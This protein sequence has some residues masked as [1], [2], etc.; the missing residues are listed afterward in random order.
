MS[1]ISSLYLGAVSPLSGSGSSALHLP[2]HHLTTHGVV[3]GMT[4]SGKSGLVTVLVEEALR[5]A[6]PVLV[7]E[8][9]ELTGSPGAPSARDLDNAVS[10]LAP[11]WFLMRDAHSHEGLA[12]LQPRWAMSYLRGPMTRSEIQRALATQPVGQGAE[13]RVLGRWAAS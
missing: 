7:I 12:L 13:R 8:G 1:R 11:R 10:H 6:V 3:V 9:L 2:A 4:G 5:A